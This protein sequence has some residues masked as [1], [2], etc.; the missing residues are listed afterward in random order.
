[1]AALM[2]VARTLRN[3]WKKSVFFTGAA[4]WGGN[5]LLD[6]YK[7]DL[8]REEYCKEAQLYGRQLSSNIAKPIKATVFVNP[9]AKKGK[10][11][12]L[13][14]KN[15]A[16][17]LH[18]AGLDVEIIQTTTEGE[19]KDLAGSLDATDII[20]IAGGDGTVAEVVTG[21][22]RRDD[23]QAISS[24]WTLGVIPVGV[25]NSLARSLYADAEADVRWMCNAAMAIIKGLTRQVDVMSIQD[26]EH[27]RKSYAMSSIHWG[28]LQDAKEKATKFWYFGPLKHR[29][30]FIWAGLTQ[31]S[32]SV[33]RGHI[34]YGHPK[35]IPEP[36]S[37]ASQGWWTRLM[38]RLWPRKKEPEPEV[39]D[40]SEEEIMEELDISAV[41]CSILTDLSGTPREG[42]P[43]LQLQTGPSEL[44]RTDFIKEG[45]TRLAGK[46]HTD[47]YKATDIPVGEVHLTPKIEEG[48][49]SWYT[50][51]NERF[52]AMPITVKILPSKLRF[53]TNRS[54][55]GQEVELKR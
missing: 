28:P 33:V 54:Q 25:T 2:R 18:L 20:V 4:I 8:L 7:A 35:E 32:P 37:Q 11:K 16:P 34:S 48:K 47:I 55:E 40:P 45:W 29:F 1:M 31:E 36:P 15:A 30:S 21:L 51:D 3:H 52:E 44:S 19:A 14:E 12:K 24:K 23:E 13:F 22:L 6:R 49:D 10:G 42:P 53:F 9:A 26:E 38:N 50:I 27:G 43:A 17:L 46:G 5:F 39:N 41:E